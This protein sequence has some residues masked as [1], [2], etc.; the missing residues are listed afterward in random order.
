MSQKKHIPGDGLGKNWFKTNIFKLHPHPHGF[1]N[2]P[3]GENP[4]VRPHKVR[5]AWADWQQ[6]SRV[7]AHGISH[8]LS[9]ENL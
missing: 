4:S 5:T 8:H 7:S 3:C 6:H 9:P 2:Q 1:F